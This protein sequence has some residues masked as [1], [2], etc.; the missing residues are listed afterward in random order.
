MT[1]TYPRLALTA[2][3]DSDAD[4]LYEFN[5]DSDGFAGH[6]GVDFGAPEW[7]GQPD[8]V[9]G[10]DGYRTVAFT[11]WFAAGRADAYTELAT[12]SRL[13]LRAD[14][15]LLVQMTEASEPRWFH[16]W[17][18]TPASLSPD[19]VLIKG[20]GD[21]AGS[22]GISVS[23]KAD[24]FLY[25]ERVTLDT[26]TIANDPTAGTNPMSV[27]LDEIVGD[28][29]VPLR[30]TVDG[31]DDIS[32][33]ES[34]LLTLTAAE[35]AVM[36]VL[37]DIG[38]GDGAEVGTDTGAPVS[39]SSYVG[40]SYREI[41]FATEADMVSRL[42]RSDPD[43]DPIEIPGIGSY[44]A[45]L[46]VSFP[47]G[48][49]STTKFALQLKAAPTPLPAVTVVPAFSVGGTVWVDLGI[50]SWPLGL[51]S[52]TD[53]GGPYGAIF[54]IYAARIS[55]AASIIVD[56]LLLIPDI[57]VVDSATSLL[58]LLPD[59]WSSDAV[60]VWDGDT[61]SFWVL[62]PDGTAGYTS[63]S[64]LAGVFP[65]AIPGRT[66]VLTVVTQI[67]DGGS[68]DVITS[69]VDVTVSYLPRFLWPAP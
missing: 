37:W 3:A 12:L 62:N 34:M 69:S 42:A 6:D 33:F 27:V 14:G 35:E 1:T 5:V 28:A 23:L 50:A 10:V 7:S 13:L 29:P 66:N 51:P 49:P 59:V 63:P 22:W 16:T 53:A 15:W 44:R 11:H 45:I 61:E 21:L 19:Q 56:A 46:R 52:T 55:G 67:G 18:S 20:D 41:S 54:E 2:S 24:P 31:L 48:D 47:D 60:A 38:T 9:G 25:G 57:D 68:G 26:V 30:I 58:T 65:V 4:V 36:P 64:P 32:R 39:D 43:T 40:G 17:R 8:A